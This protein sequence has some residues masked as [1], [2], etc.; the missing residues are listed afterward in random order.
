[1]TLM[2]L[3]VDKQTLADLA[4]FPNGQQKQA[5]LIL[6][7]KTKTIGGQE[8]L[9]EMFSTPLT[10][11]KEIKERI[12]VFAYLHGN[13]LRINIDKNVCDFAEFYLRG[14]SPVRKFPFYI[15]LLNRIALTFKNK[16]DYYIIQQ[17]VFSTIKL[18]EELSLFAD[19]LTE[20]AP[21]LLLAYKLEIAKTLNS[22]D[23]A[24]IKELKGKAKFTAVDTAKADH[25]FKNVARPAIKRL[26]MVTYQLD[27]YLTVS[28]SSKTKGFTLPVVTTS[29]E[30][31]LTFKG[32][33]H[34]FVDH[35][36]G[37]DVEL[38]TERNICFITG[39]NMAGKSTLLTFR[40]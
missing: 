26:L 14:A 6:L 31:T 34:P 28:A 35:P 30:A 22:A 24:W 39:T 3:D 12:A 13:D 23:F 10:D 36:I 25:L 27:V 17:G 37:N 21:K 16:N 8:Q 29:H 33:F 15:I 7:G 32:L 20:E 19:H 5:I 40:S 1:M 18:L 4:L 11:S 9:S 38:D 2:N